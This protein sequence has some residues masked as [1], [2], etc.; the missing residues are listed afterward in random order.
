MELSKSMRD[1]LTQVEFLNEV[2]LEGIVTEVH[3]GYEFLG[4]DPDLSCK[5]GKDDI[6]EVRPGLIKLGIVN[7]SPTGDSLMQDGDL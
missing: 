7:P 3:D 1:R 6:L 5:F 2:R 4:L